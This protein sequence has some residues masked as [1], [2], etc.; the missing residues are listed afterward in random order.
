V[1]VLCLNW[2]TIHLYGDVWIA[3]HRLRHRLFVERLGWDLPSCHGMEY[4]AFD[5]PAAEY[6]LWLDDAGDTR[7]AV[8]LL[9]TTQPYMLQELWPDMIACEPPCSGLVWEA[10]RFGCD[11]DL[12]APIRRRAVAEMLCGM[13]EFGLRRGIEK[14][15][16]VM[17]LRLLKRVVVD[18]GCEVTVLG[19]ERTIGRLQ[20]AASYLRVSR[21]VLTEIRKRASIEGSV[22]RTGLPVAACVF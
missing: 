20:A 13:Q 4:D 19:P 5:T 1:T 7:G 21:N 6:L 22:L 12:D 14:F 16:A 15:L 18:A 17:Q 2:E 3:H 8:R 11:R 9:P 10:T